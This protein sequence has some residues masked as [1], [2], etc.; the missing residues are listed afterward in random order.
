MQIS[1]TYTYNHLPI[2][3]YWKKRKI[4]FLKQVQCKQNNLK[5][6]GLFHAF[7]LISYALF[8][9]WMNCLVV[10]FSS[11][12]KNSNGKDNYRFYC[13]VWYKNS[14]LYILLDRMINCN[15]FRLCNA[16]IAIISYWIKPRCKAELAMTL[17]PIYHYNCQQNFSLI[18]K[19]VCFLHWNM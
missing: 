14:Y 8:F 15:G 1:H 18:G 9:F 10:C 12:F 16:Y 5:W 6:N 13:I 19:W 2:S 17:N 3:I 7:I 4:S 11:P